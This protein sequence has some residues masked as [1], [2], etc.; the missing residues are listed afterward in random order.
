VYK[1]K[2]IV[3]LMICSMGVN[4]FIGNREE[5]RKYSLIMIFASISQNAAVELLNR[6]GN[7]L[8]TVTSKVCGEIVKKIMGGGE[9][10]PIERER[11][12]KGGENGASDYAV[13]I[14]GNMNINK[15]QVLSED[16]SKSG[17]GVIMREDRLLKR[18][19]RDKRGMGER[20]K[21]VILFLIFI[22]GI[23]QRKGIGEIIEG[24]I[25]KKGKKT[26]ISA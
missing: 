16:E 15:K 26:R 1:K 4:G 25:N 13:I 12:K 23:R 9:E 5:I 17:Y 3:V 6:C 7:S 2:V 22:I 19:E 20:E 18:G 10:E 21:V 11:E 24:Y 8:M 14:S